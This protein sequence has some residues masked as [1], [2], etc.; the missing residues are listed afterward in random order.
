VFLWL[1]TLS[2]WWWIA[3]ALILGAIE[4]LSMSLFLL[5]PAAAALLMAPLVALMPGMPGE[6]RLAVFAALAIALTFIGRALVRR[7][8]DGGASSDRT[9]NSRAAQMVGRR[10]RLLSA[11]DGELRVEIDGTQWAARLE[12]ET[13]VTPGVLVEVTGAQGMTLKVRPRLNRS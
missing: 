4:M 5:W 2:P 1:E 3:F 9:L 10:G 7:Y 11:T 12:D 13:P 8:G 6:L